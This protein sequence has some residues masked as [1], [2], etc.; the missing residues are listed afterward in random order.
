MASINFS[1]SAMNL[2]RAQTNF[3]TSTSSSPQIKIITTPIRFKSSQQLNHQQNSVPRRQ[4]HI[5]N[6]L[7][8]SVEPSVSS[9]TS[10]QET[11]L[12][13]GIVG[14][15]TFGQFLAKAFQRQGHKVLGTSR[16]DY[17][18]YCQEHGIEFFHHLNGLCEAQ[19]DVL[20]VCS[21][22]VSTEKIIKE[23]PFHKLK[24]NTIIADVLSVKQYPKNL[25]LDVVPPEFGILCTHP[26]FG[27]VSGKNGWKGLKFQYEKVRTRMNN[28][29]EG[30][31]E[32]FLNIFQDEG[33]QMVEMSCEEHDEYAAKSQFLTHTV[34]RILSNMD[35]EATPI[36]TKGY[37]TLLELTRNTVSDSSDLYDGLFLYNVNSVKQ[38]QDLEKALDTVKH[39]LFSKLRESFREQMHDTKESTAPLQT[40][41]FLPSSDK[42]LKDVSSFS[43]LPEQA[44]FDALEVK[45]LVHHGSN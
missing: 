22:I 27:P 41:Q 36:D 19:P 30:K 6:N 33:C 43:M 40:S 17:S 1:I 11:P 16:S 39:T 10:K 24:P 25:M 44:N 23:I 38:I 29:Q 4:S 31:C 2:H 12:R 37:E 28:I 9:P 14:L 34:A 21:S 20:L 5:T 13:I 18:E 32:Q 3:F 42:H 35:L 7:Y 26:M 15:G 8:R 45:K